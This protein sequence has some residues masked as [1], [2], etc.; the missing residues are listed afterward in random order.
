MTPLGH[1]QQA[2]NAADNAAWVS[3]WAG[4]VAAS[5]TTAGN[6]PMAGAATAVGAAS[7]LFEQMVRPNWKKSLFDSNIDFAVS[8]GTGSYPA[9]APVFTELG[10]LVKKQRN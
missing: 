3:S 8:V 6:A 4:R 10:E 2:F 7:S 5:A 1:F 9:L